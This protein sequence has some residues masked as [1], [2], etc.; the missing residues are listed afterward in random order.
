MLADVMVPAESEVDANR[1]VS[2]FLN[3]EGWF[4]EPD[5]V[6]LVPEA[7]VHDTRLTRLFRS[8][9]E[10]GLTAELSPFA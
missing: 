7:P 4:A 9:Q 3:H 2:E 8:A 10:K 5:H 1:V 6:E